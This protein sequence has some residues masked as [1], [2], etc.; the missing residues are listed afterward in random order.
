[1]PFTPDYTALFGAQLNRSITSSIN[2]FV[3][4][5]AV[6]SGEFQY[7]EANTRGQEAYSLV[8]VR[9]GA[10]SK[11]LFGEL[12]VRNAFQTAVCAN[13]DSVPVC[14][15]GVHR[16]EWPASYLRRQSRSDILDDH[17]HAGLTGLGRD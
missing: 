12:W 17:Y 5:E 9:A 10:R 15:I 6:L 13:R 8:N 4:G 1:M 7:D 16:R 11:Y 3:R 14:A 2:A